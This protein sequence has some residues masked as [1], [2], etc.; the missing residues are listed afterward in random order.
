MIEISGET[1]A[2]KMVI[3]RQIANKVWINQVVKGE[4]IRQEGFNPSY[5][6]IRGNKISR[7]N[8]MATVVTKFLSEDENYG[9]LT[10]DDGTETIRVKAF[11][12]DVIKIKNARIGSIVALV[13]KLKHYQNET[14]ISPEVAR[15]I[16]DP[17]WLIVRRLEIGK[18]IEVKEEPVEEKKEA[19]KAEEKK[20]AI[21]TIKISPEKEQENLNDKL[22]NMIKAQDKGEGA[23]MDKVL[24]EMK[25]DKDE[26][27]SL[28]I[29]LLKSGDLFEPKKGMLKVLD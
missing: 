18:P 21:E 23:D 6:E 4:F 2:K 26:C 25:I 17:N 7:V 13:G 28:I 5:I 16:S 22:L 12:P 11:G 19:P 1:K 29:G 27:K 9:T 8:L 3:Q 14:Y 15:E 10:L 24:D 20:E